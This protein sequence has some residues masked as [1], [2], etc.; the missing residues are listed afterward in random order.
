M[1]IQQLRTKIHLEDKK[2]ENRVRMVN[3]LTKCNREL[4]IVMRKTAITQKEY[5]FGAKASRAESRLEESWMPLYQT[6]DRA[7]ALY[8]TLVQNWK[9]EGHNPHTDT[10]IRLSTYRARIDEERFEIVFCSP[11]HAPVKWQERE[12]LLA[13]RATCNS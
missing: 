10:M 1:G 6:R 9:C 3:R 13:R 12:I 8:R 5:T 11:S 7:T 2:N 4:G